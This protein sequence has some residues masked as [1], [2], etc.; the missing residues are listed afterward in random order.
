MVAKFH[1]DMALLVMLWS[2]SV[3][4]KNKLDRKSENAFNCN[5]ATNR[6]MSI[7]LNLSFC[8]TTGHD[9]ARARMHQHECCVPVA[10]FL[11]HTVDS[12]VS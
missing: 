12:S 11:T 2:N 1:G 9:V 6:P 3:D 4:G 7:T 5:T 10:T 8:N